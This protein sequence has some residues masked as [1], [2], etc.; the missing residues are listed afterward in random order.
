MSP[1]SSSTT[2]TGGQSDGSALLPAPWAVLALLLATASW[3]SL[4]LVGKQV[5]GVLD[6][7]WFTL[8]RYVLATALLVLLVQCFGEAPW[9]KLRRHWWR[10]SLLG[11]CGYGLFSLLVFYGLRLSVPSH[12]SVIMATMPF[13]T[14]A[15]RWALDGQRPAL[16]ALLAAALAIVGVATVADL[17]GQYGGLSTTTLIGDALALA[18]TLGWV[19]YTRGAASLPALSALEYTALTAV[20]VLPWLS[21]FTLAA[22]ALGWCPAPTPAAVADVAPQL[23]YIAVLPTVAAALAFNLGVRRLGAPAGTLF[24]NMVPV[25]VIAVRAVL[26]N[27]PQTNELI[28]TA[29]VGMALVLNAWPARSSGA[30]RPAGAL[31]SGVSS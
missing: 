29:L 13:T 3:G 16:R 9:H 15:L 10:I 4:F 21:L 26:G 17:F 11:A 31:A 2:S 23:I 7:A 1:L 25:S 12:G 18:G 6:P 22:T 14:L 30:D 8:L 19:I 20:G 28:G 27:A 5:L 24:L